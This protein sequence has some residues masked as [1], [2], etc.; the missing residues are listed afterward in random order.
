MMNEKGN[1]EEYEQKAFGETMIDG[2]TEILA[3]ILLLSLPVIFAHPYL[4][5]F[6]AL[7]VIYGQFA[8]DFIRE[9]TTYPR[10]GRVELK[11]EENPATVK[12]SLLELLLLLLGSILITFMTMIIVEGGIPA[13]ESVY[14]SLYRWIPLCFGLIMFG[15]SLYLVEKSGNRYYY[16]VGIFTSLLGLLMAVL[17]FPGEKDG[18]YLYF[19]IL[20]SL[21]LI[22]GIARHILFIR[23]YPVIDMEEE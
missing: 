2:I 3:G 18:L 15:P 17:A 22:T 13:L 11:I 20:G 10:I 16:L 6:I 23:K 1:L 8:L 7:F 14:E 21:S 9:R 19:I 12:R 5:V 4:V